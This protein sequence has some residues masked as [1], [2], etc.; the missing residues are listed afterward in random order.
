MEKSP[1][2]AES[3]HTNRRNFLKVLGF[4]G[5]TLVAGKFIETLYKHLSADPEQVVYF[6]NFKVTESRRELGVYDSTG[7]A[8]LVIDKEDY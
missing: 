7:D 8:I 2:S 1:S 4:G 5:A 6:R 3:L